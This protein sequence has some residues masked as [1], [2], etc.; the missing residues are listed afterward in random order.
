MNDILVSFSGGRTSAFMARY[1][2]SK[3]EADPTTRLHFVFANT[4]KEREET[5]EFVQRCD[6]EWGLGVVWVESLVDPENGIGTS[7]TVVDFLTASRNGEPFEAVI[8]K[9][10][11]PNTAFPHCTRELKLRPITSYMKSIGVKDYYSAVG[12]RHDE[13]HRI[14]REK[15]QKEKYI[16]PLADESKVDSAFIRSWWSKQC[17]DLNLRDYEGNCDMCWKKSK[18]K[19]LTMITEKPELIEWWSEME[20][21]YGGKTALTFFRNNESAKDLIKQ[22]KRPFV[23][24][25]DTYELSQMQP[26]FFS[27]MDSELDCFCK[28][29]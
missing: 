17:F 19:L 1:L 18:R 12:I 5:L 26:S 29:T 2:Q 6:K 25:I 28:S 15:A 27:D 7:H 20:I 21:K 24:A 13:A 8:A 14:N 3:Y 9:Y 4:G 10:S 16:Y 23:K 22:A 11:L